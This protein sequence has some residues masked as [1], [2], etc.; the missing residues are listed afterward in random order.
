MDWK[1]LEDTTLLELVDQGRAEALSE[2]YDRYG[3]LVYSVALQ[4][5]GE[6]PAAEEITLDVFMAVWEKAALYRRERGKVTTWL[7]TICRN[8]AIDSLRRKGSRLERRSVSWAEISHLDRIAATEPDRN[9]E[10]ATDLS[11]QRERVRAAIAQL[12]A[13]QR[14]ALALAYFKG[15]TQREI[16]AELDQPLGT[17]KTRIR[18]AMQKLKRLLEEAQ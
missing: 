18:L 6:R 3:R 13:E 2:L 5:A 10:R 7:T 8:R 11:M 14:Q 4:V 9:P 15:Y 16:A 17:V 12:P 1:A